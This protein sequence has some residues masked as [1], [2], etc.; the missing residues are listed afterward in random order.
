M[1]EIGENTGNIKEK[2]HE[3]TQ[4]NKQATAHSNQPNQA[5]QTNQR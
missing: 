4:S 1:A 2:H 5:N 3:R